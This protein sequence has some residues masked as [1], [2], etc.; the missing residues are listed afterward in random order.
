MLTSHLLRSAGVAAAFLAASTAF[1]QTPQLQFP[2]ASPTATLKQR[3]GLTDVEITYARPG[4]KGRTIF[5]GLV[6][7]GEVWRTGANNATKVVFSTPVKFGGADVPAGTYGLFTI[8]GEK[9]WTV[10]LNSNP[11]QWGAYRYDA[12]H[13]VV[14]VKAVPE[15]LA[16]A[17][18]TFTIDVNDIR[19][20][21]ATLA[22]SW[23][24]TRVPVKLE[25]DL[26]GQLVPAIEAAMAAPGD[27]K[28]Y[29]QAAMFYHDHDVDLKKAL[30]WVDAA[31]AEQERFWMMYLK[32]RIHAKMGD[33]P[34]AIAAATK[35]RE[36][37]QAAGDSSY[38]RQAEA[39]VAS[40]R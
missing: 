8:P 1:A 23:E 14:R 26:K 4:A 10:I 40:L 17:V 29:F 20:D 38:V 37:A 7:F 6:A 28:P 3:V 18:E 34:A 9:E 33:K 30:T 21:S 35:T 27:K 12:S 2:A 25:I 39:L 11:E 36:L 32:A 19:D 13:D 5:G 24:K 31:L 15:K 22:L 16:T